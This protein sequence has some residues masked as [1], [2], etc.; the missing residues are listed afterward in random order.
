MSSQL[1]ISCHQLKL[2]VWVLSYI[3]VE[4]LAN[5]SEGKPQTKPQAFTKTID[6]SP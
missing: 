2:P 4:L 6:R 3:P 1:A 5:G